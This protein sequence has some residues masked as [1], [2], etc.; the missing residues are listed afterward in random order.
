MPA[1]TVFL[2]IFFFNNFSVNL[3]NILPSA[4]LSSIVL[5]KVGFPQLTAVGIPA[6]VVRSASRVPNPFLL[7]SSC[8]FFPA[9]LASPG[10]LPELSNL[11]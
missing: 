10:G 1:D 3:A 7:C 4:P 6:L 11:I 8:P 9:L 2:T 5:A